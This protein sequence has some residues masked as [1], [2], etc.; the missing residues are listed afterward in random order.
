MNNNNEK[1]KKCNYTITCYRWYDPY[2]MCIGVNILIL[3][4]RFL[5]DLRWLQLDI[6]KRK[7]II[8]WNT[9]DIIA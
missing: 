2:S 1:K 5:L 9:M 7:L 6:E 4:F 8:I 3:T